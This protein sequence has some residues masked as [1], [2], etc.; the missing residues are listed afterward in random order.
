VPRNQSYAPPLFPADEAFNAWISANHA[1]QDTAAADCCGED[2]SI[3]EARAD[4]EQRDR[5]A[6]RKA[7]PSQWWGS[8]PMD[9]VDVRTDIESVETTVPE[10]AA[11]SLGVR[12]RGDETVEP[13]G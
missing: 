11:P 6:V 1:P 4:G 10:E 5:Y 8:I 13:G 7:L 2:G 9:G 3:D 12:D